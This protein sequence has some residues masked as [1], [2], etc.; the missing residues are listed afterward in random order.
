MKAFHIPSVPREPGSLVPLGAARTGGKRQL[1]PTASIQKQALYQ[2]WAFR[3]QLNG[4]S[5][6]SMLQEGV[7]S[8]LLQA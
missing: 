5:G 3:Q 6:S 1:Q 2:S 4:F 7:S 8:D